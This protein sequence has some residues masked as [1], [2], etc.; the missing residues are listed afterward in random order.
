MVKEVKGM[1]CPYGELGGQ[2]GKRHITFLAGFTADPVSVQLITL[3]LATCLLD[4]SFEMSTP[5]S[6][7][8]LYISPAS[9]R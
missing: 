4:K 1:T 9:Y 7:A 2:L 3:Q 8:F 6:I 5:A